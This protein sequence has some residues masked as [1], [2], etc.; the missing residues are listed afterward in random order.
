M[1]KADKN[2]RIVPPFTLPSVHYA[3]S[4]VSS[5]YLRDFQQRE[6]VSQ[7]GV[8]QQHLEEQGEHQFWT[9]QRTPENILMKA[10]LSLS[11]PSVWENTT[12]IGP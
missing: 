1:K 12:L 2:D 9:P 5:A 7:A 11:G 10:N 4:F 6:K 3:L 8:S